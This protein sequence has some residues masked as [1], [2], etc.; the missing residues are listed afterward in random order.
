MKLL[1]IKLEEKCE[2]HALD[3]G[4]DALFCCYGCKLEVSSFT[5][6]YLISVWI[7]FHI[8]R[9]K[10]YYGIRLVLSDADGGSNFLKNRFRFQGIRKT[11]NI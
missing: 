4:R 5:H 3:F 9:F 1:R 2:M 11:V 6:S 10:K 7:L 8:L